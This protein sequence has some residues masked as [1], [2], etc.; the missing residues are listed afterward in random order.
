MDNYFFKFPAY[1]VKVQNH[2]I[3]NATVG[4]MPVSS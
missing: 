1:I 3:Y 4:L 2:V